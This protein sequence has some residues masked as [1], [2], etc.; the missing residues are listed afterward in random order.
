M[1][2]VC[3][4]AHYEAAIRCVL[5][6]QVVELRYCAW[7]WRSLRRPA[8]ACV[9]D[10]VANIRLKLVVMLPQMK[11]TI[12]LPDDKTRLQLDKIEVCESQRGSPEGDS[13]GQETE[14]ERRERQERR[15]VGDTS[16][17]DK[18]SPDGKHSDGGSLGERRSVSRSSNR[19]SSGLGHLPSYLE[20]R[21]SNSHAPKQPPDERTILRAGGYQASTTNTSPNSTT[22]T[23]EWSLD[24]DDEDDLDI[25][26]I[27]DEVLLSPEEPSI[28][29]EEQLSPESP[30][31]TRD[32][33]GTSTSRVTRSPQARDIHLDSRDRHSDARESLSGSRDNLSGSRD[34]LSGSRDSL[35]G[36]RDRLTSTHDGLSGSRDRLTGSRERLSDS[37]ERHPESRSKRMSSR[38]T[39]SFQGDN[40]ENGERGSERLSAREVFWLR[41]S[42]PRWRRKVASADTSP[43]EPRRNR[44][45]RGWSIDGRGSHSDTE[46]PDILYDRRHLL[47]KDA[48]IQSPTSHSTASPPSPHGMYTWPPQHN[49]HRHH[50]S[51]ENDE[52]ENEEDSSHQQSSQRAGDHYDTMT[53]RRPSTSSRY[54]A[55][56]VHDAHRF[57]ISP[58]RSKPSDSYDSHSHAKD[59]TS[60]HQE[61]LTHYYRHNTLFIAHLQRTPNHQQKYSSSSHSAEGQSRHVESGGRKRERSPP[62]LRDS[63][64][65]HL[66]HPHE[67]DDPY[68]YHGLAPTLA[69]HLSAVYSPR[70]LP[71]H[72]SYDHPEDY[73]PTS[74]YGSPW[75]FLGLQLL[76][77]LSPFQ[78][79][80]SLCL[81]FNLPLPI[82]YSFA[83]IRPHATIQRSPSLASSNIL[84]HAS[85]SS[86]V[87]FS[88]SRSPTTDVINL[89]LFGLACFFRIP[90]LAMNLS[91]QKSPPLPVTLLPQHFWSCLLRRILITMENF[92]D[93]FLLMAA[94]SPRK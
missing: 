83:L 56:P 19:R 27:C 73:L 75:C 18:K 26:D 66:M 7:A 62:Q 30:R 1:A 58:R 63:R 65:R 53:L 32:P 52:Y 69:P 74:I 38:H 44:F 76:G 29:W 24:D 35:S 36:S 22:N 93:L 79:V 3:F 43:E 84:Y 4:P 45:G 81:R 17:L 10:R 48:K 87:P 55:S 51:S 89:L 91:S 41:T 16:T 15:A 39:T 25:S 42:R 88:Y 59:K 67:A 11:A 2:A 78:H 94:L 49:R 54:D 85:F 68:I 47:S 82:P 23:T 31:I 21:R 77:T 13:G 90:L 80:L 37:R 6:G 72:F 57:D 64:P 92:R 61:K 28:D 5:P 70:S 46:D 50:S 71:T 34:R 12:T 33:P 14:D 60:K 8:W 9:G 20:R 86:P 40:I